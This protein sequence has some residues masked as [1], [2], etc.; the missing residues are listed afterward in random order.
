LAFILLVFFLKNSEAVSLISFEEAL[1]LALGSFKNPPL[2]AITL[3]VTS[4]AF[5]APWPILDSETL[6]VTFSAHR[7]DLTVVN[8]ALTANQFTRGLQ[9]FIDYEKFLNRKKFLCLK[10]FPRLDAASKFLNKPGR[11]NGGLVVE[12][13]LDLWVV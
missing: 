12:D 3:E 7:N 8:L 6:L 2:L 10:T 13:F 4:E 5:G 9:F 11:S 1:V